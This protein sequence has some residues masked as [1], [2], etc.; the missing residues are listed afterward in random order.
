MQFTKYILMGAMGLM[1]VMASAAPQP[2]STGFAVGTTNGAT[3]LSYA[4]IPVGGD[5]AAD[6][7][8]RVQFI[9]AGSDLA[10]SQVQFYRVL[11]SITATYTNSTVTLFVNSTNT[12][13]AWQSGTV[14]IW[15]GLD[16]KYEKRTLT[17][18]TG[19][20]NVVVTAAT[21]GAVRPGD[22]LYKVTTTGA[23]AITW[24]ASTNSLVGTGSALYIGQRQS[25]LLVEINATT[26][27][28]INVVSGDYIR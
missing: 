3:T 8:P 13:D 5:T 10:T 15:H 25:P 20:T 9:N 16:G 27:G 23:G 12:G 18:N 19:S 14:L 11:S 6:S 22:K 2:A 21:L 7:A 17:A 26:A 28:A 1:G 24:G 4:V